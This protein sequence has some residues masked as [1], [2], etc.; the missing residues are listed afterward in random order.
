MRVWNK[1]H[2]GSWHLYGH[3]HY[4]LDKREGTIGK[5]FD[6]GVDN[7]VCNYSPLS[8]QEVANIMNKKPIQEID[9]HVGLGMLER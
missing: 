1:S 3:S 6:I 5:S 7:P 9:H 8:L 4:S 2:H